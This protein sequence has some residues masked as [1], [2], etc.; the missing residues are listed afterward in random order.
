MPI[1][2]YA[3]KHCKHTLDALQKMSDDPLV[4]CP[5]CGEPA[6]KKLLSAPR[7]RLKGAGWYE[8]DFKKDNQRNVLKS[9]SEPAKTEKKEKKSETKKSDDKSVTKAKSKSESK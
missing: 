1:Y 5:E 7:F 4:D 6:L 9:D 2:E 3:C 8:T